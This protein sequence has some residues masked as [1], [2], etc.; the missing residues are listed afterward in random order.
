MPNIKGV[1]SYFCIY[2]PAGGLYSSD[3]PITNKKH[4]LMLFNLKG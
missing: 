2:R 4:H 1:A 3:A